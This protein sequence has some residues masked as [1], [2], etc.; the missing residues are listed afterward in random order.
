MLNPF[1][2]VVGHYLAR[3]KKWS[4]IVTR[5][6]V[7]TF[8][9]AMKSPEHLR[10]RSLTFFG[11]ESEIAIAHRAP[12]AHFSDEIRIRNTRRPLPDQQRFR[13][14]RWPD[15]PA[16]VR[17]IGPLVFIADTAARQTKNC[18]SFNAESAEHCRKNDTPHTC[19]TLAS[20]RIPAGT[21]E[22]REFDPAP[23][24]SWGY[25]YE[26]MRRYPSLAYSAPKA[27]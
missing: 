7:N 23:G 16:L 4:P 22:Q 1:A 26:E 9:V 3:L 8:T 18:A 12:N 24:S 6:G 19:Y 13:I 2:E 15:A 27:A 25:D 14:H 10:P 11:S 20:R 5:R 17:A 21:E